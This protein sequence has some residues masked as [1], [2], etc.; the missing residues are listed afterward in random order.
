MNVAVMDST[1]NV[2]FRMKY[3]KLYDA[4]LSTP[5]RSDEIALGEVGWALIQAASTPSPSS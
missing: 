1:F 3:A 2:F 5:M 4:A